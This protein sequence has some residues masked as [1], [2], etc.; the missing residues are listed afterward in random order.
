VRRAAQR[1]RLRLA[2]LAGV[3]AAAVIAVAI[4]AGLGAFSQPPRLEQPP[5]APTLYIYASTVGSAANRANAVIP[6]NTATNTPGKPIHVGVGGAWPGG[7]IVITPDGKTAY[8]TTASGT[9]TPI[10]TA[11]GTPGKP[12]HIHGRNEQNR[13]DFIAITPDGKTAYVSHE[14]SRTV[15]PVTTATNTPDKPI[16]IRGRFPLNGGQIVITPDGKTAYVT[17]WT[18]T[19]TPINTATN[20]PGK[21]IPVVGGIAI[22]PDGKTAYVTTDSGV[23]PINTATGTLGKPIN[24]GGGASERIV[25][26]PDGKTAYVTTVNIKRCQENYRC[27]YTV[28]PISTAT[29]TP[30]KPIHVGFSSAYFFFSGQIAITPDG[31]TAY[32]A[33]QNGCRIFEPCTYTVTPISTATN[34]PGKPIPVGGFGPYWFGGQ[35]VI[36]PDGKTAYVNTGSGVTPISTATNTPGNPIHVPGGATGGIA[37]TP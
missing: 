19:I 25:I 2:S 14:V 15:T 12:I 17:T 3:A 21:P 23:T 11:T 35:I 30:G 28:T 29:G 1:Q 37:I 4:P 20:T 5:A 10:N 32:V 13:P 36:T 26:T 24:I 8:V 7:M 33:S 6:V 9:I 31:K 16:N 18:G 34:T 27:P 22:T